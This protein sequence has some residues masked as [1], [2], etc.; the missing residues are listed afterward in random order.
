MAQRLSVRRSVVSGIVSIILI[1]NPLRAQRAT[2]GDL[3]GTVTADAGKAVAD[4]T[5][6][7]TRNDG[8]GAQT[9]VSDA[10]GAFRM[11]G[12]APGLYH[13]TARR[14]GFREAQLRS[15]RIVSGQ[16]TE[17]HVSLTTSPTQLSTV[18]VRVSPTSIDASTSELARR[19]GVEDVGLVPAGRD[20]NS[21]IELVPGATKGFVWGGAG[22][23][24]NNYQIDG[25]SVNHPGI[26]G[27]F[28]SP[29][30]DWIEALEVRGLGAGA[31]SGEF[32]GAIINAVTKTGSNNWRGSVRANYISPSLT[33]TNIKPNEEG[34]EQSMRRELSGE[35]SGPIVRDRLYYFLGGIIVDRAIHVPDLSTIDLDDLRSE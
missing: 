10:A 22:D 21:L 11:R 12:L 26:G 30:I 33:S 34:A 9:A 19:V 18:E 13:I 28:L 4:A 27:D 24:A 29:S 14:I 16:T 3:S 8:T 5:L 20:A 31:E 32:Q 17:V 6:Q 15:L 7:I 25:V 23:A 35:I 1:A 2:T